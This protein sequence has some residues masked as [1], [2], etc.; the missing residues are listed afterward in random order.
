MKKTTSILTL[1]LLVALGAQASDR[2]VTTLTDGW[3]FTKGEATHSTRW[4]DVK[5]PHDWAIYGP[6]D[7]AN[8]LQEVAITQNGETEKTWK[9][10]R[11]GGLP[12]IG[13]GEYLSLI[14]I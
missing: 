10:G 8:D 2:K 5:V 14:H 3:Q 11:T 6:F 1:S 9:T 13:K 7:R 4:Q 12:F